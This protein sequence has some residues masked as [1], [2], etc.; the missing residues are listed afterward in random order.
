[1]KKWSDIKLPLRPTLVTA[2]VMLVV[3][4][5][6][7]VGISAY[8]NSVKATNLL[9]SNLSKEI[10]DLTTNKT[11]NYFVAGPEF[12][13]YTEKMSLFHEIDFSDPFKILT[14]CASA[15][16]AF[17]NFFWV[18]YATN[19]GE[20]FAARHGTDVEGEMIGI[21]YQIQKHPDD[22][23]NSTLKRDY[24]FKEGQWILEGTS[25]NN[26][27]PR[28]RPYWTV[29]LDNPTGGWTSPYVF[30]DPPDG[31]GVTYIKP[32]KEDGHLQG[33]WL[34]DYFL[35]VITKYLISLKVGEN[36]DVLLVADDGTLIA[37]SNTE[38]VI[39]LSSGKLKVLGKN[40][41]ETLLSEAWEEL[42]TYNIASPDFTA[43][44]FQFGD[45]LGYIQSF[46]NDSNVPWNVLTIVPK[47]DFFKP[48]INQAWKASGFALGICFFCAL[49]AAFFFGHI[50]SRLREIAQDMS[51][52]GN[53]ELTSTIFSDKSS[54]VLEV[55]LMNQALD[56]MKTGLSS[57][58]K[59]VPIDLVSMLIRSGFP[60]K[61]G[62]KK[63]PL[64]TLFVDLTNF[65]T[66]AESEVPEELVKVLDDYLYEM[67][68]I[69][70]THEGT[71]DKYIGDGIM[72][73]WGAPLPNASHALAAC[74]GALAMRDKAKSL[75]KNF[76][77]THHGIELNL[78]IGINSGDAIVG[79]FGSAERMDYTAVGDSVNLANRLETLNKV[80]GTQILIGEE[81]ARQV[82][83]YVLIRPIDFVAVKGKKHAI[84]IYELISHQKEAASTYLEAIEVYKEGMHQLSRREFQMAI[85]SFEKAKKLFGGTDK[86]S[87]I[88]LERARYYINNPPPKDW[89][90]SIHQE[91]K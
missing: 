5:G 18:Y 81:T 43:A 85:D 4:T 71:V 24:R 30:T 82:E 59:Y 67:S 15:L 75:W 77:D 8:H 56:R 34:I 26:Y 32:L 11:L 58:A 16:S 60:A 62:G 10:S 80:Y 76:K 50:S 74:R 87:D 53:F 57:F 54:F 13:E 91:L 84:V 40:S 86:P 66:L 89:D 78:R 64:T 1:M 70:R 6:L 29:G 19:E 38:S 52:V 3:I 2:V 17:P 28:E 69:I 14:H 51:K 47:N 45:Y 22:P 9:W 48:I 90:G 42:K 65:T 35:N 44:H 12:L 33:M 73:F 55:N 41:K 21:W 83:S 37:S 39:D 25:W 79:N 72:A 63:I 61:V 49:I 68:Y 7:G 36:G 31:I 27:D 88:L 46:P 23:Q 20:L